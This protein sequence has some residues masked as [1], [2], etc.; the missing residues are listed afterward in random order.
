MITLS[1]LKNTDRPKIKVQ[2]IGR[3]M[4]SK[5]GK[6]CGRGHKGDK[7]R[8]G[9]KQTFRYEGGQLPLYRKLPCRGFGNGM[10]RSHVFAI[11]IGRINE[12]FNDGETVNLETLKSKGCSTRR[13]LGGLKI[14]AGGELKKKVSIEAHA[15]SAAAKQQLEDQAVTFT[16]I[17]E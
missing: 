16:L 12:L 17:T 1:T 6:T 13:A 5:R 7:A 9:Y 3:G 11:S 8:Q 14:L 2:R 4:G 10:F 15:I